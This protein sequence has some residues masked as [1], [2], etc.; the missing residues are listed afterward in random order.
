MTTIIEFPYNSMAEKQENTNKRPRLRILS[1][2]LELMALCRIRDF[3]I[4]YV[5]CISIK[6]LVFT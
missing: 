1:T 6:I 5:S 2:R 3:T 4:K